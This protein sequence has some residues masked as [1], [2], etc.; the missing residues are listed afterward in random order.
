M[1]TTHEIAKWIKPA[2]AQTERA[3]KTLAEKYGDAATIPMKEELQKM[4][5]A[6]S[7]LATMP[8]TQLEEYINKTKK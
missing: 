2:I 6:A 7:Q 8:N 3:I 4:R 5:T 1:A